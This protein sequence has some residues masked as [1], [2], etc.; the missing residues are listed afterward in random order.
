M[1]RL[2][3]LFTLLQA[4]PAMTQSPP[5]AHSYPFRVGETFEYVGKLGLL[6]LGSASMSVTG[7]DTVRGVETFVFRFALKASTIVFKMDDV[8]LSW[9]ST[10]DLNSRRFHTDFDEGGEIRRRYYEIYPDSAM[11]TERVRSERGVSVPDPLDDAAFFYFVRTLPLEVGRTYS[12]D[13]YF[14]KNK[15]PVTIEVQKRESCDL[16]NDQKAT[17]LVLH[18]VVNADRNG[19]FSPRADAQIWLTDDSRRI[20]AQVRSRL[21]FGTVTLRLRTL[22]LGR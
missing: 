12:F 22:Q 9:A 7:L 2:V 4:S 13:R 16:P 17:C 11:F 21:S 8:M 6:T 14:R 1:S 20:I 3:A 5:G 18:P 19:M 15:N 10:A